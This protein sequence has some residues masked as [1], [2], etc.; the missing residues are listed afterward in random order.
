M[1]EHIDTYICIEEDMTET[2]QNPKEIEIAV[3]LC[4]LLISLLEF[5]LL[6]GEVSIYFCVFFFF[7]GVFKMK[8]VLTFYKYT[9]F[10]SSGESYLFV[11]GGCGI[12]VDR[13]G[14][15]GRR[16][17]RRAKYLKE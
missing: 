1:R 2:L 17:R 16:E 11:G 9:Y 12:I 13:E 3:N 4:L 6:R 5:V 8:L 7:F 15:E 10:F 14:F